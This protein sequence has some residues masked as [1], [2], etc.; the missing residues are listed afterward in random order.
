ME[1]KRQ[2]FVRNSETAKKCVE[3]CVMLNN[4]V[5]AVGLCVDVCDDM[6]RR[7]SIK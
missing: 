4:A 5:T 2:D 7:K 6:F 3:S 1:V